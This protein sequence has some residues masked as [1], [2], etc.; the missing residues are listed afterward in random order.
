[1]YVSGK[2]ETRSRLK[3]ERVMSSSIVCSEFSLD[4]NHLFVGHV[5]PGSSNSTLERWTSSDLQPTPSLTNRKLGSVRSLRLKNDGEEIAWTGDST[6]LLS[7]DGSKV[8]CARRNNKKEGPSFDYVDKPG[9]GS[10]NPR[11][12]G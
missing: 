10:G 12:R 7:L 4:G 11:R 3:A 8:S 5:E 9:S 1:M 6:G 2:L